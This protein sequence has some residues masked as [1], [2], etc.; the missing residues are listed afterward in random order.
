LKS[1]LNSAFFDTHHVGVWKNFFFTPLM[2]MHEFL[3][4]FPEAH[5][6][7]KFF[8]STV[9]A[10]F[11]SKWSNLRVTGIK[12]KIFIKNWLTL[13][14][15]RHTQTGQ[16]HTTRSD[17]TAAYYTFIQ[18]SCILHIHTGQLHTTHSYR[19]AAYY[20]FIQDSCMLGSSDF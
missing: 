8:F 4:P 5:G 11:T 20:T 12:N 15:I 2:C 9:F 6:R 13:S 7:S 17:R 16:L 18:D 3:G 14:C 19:T 1:A 10:C